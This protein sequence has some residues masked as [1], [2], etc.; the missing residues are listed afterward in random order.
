MKTYTREH[1]E[2]RIKGSGE[3]QIELVPSAGGGFQWRV[4]V[5][6]DGVM[7]TEVTSSAPAR[8][9]DLRFGASLPQVFLVKVLSGSGG[10]LR[11]VH[12]RSFEPAQIEDRHTIRI[13][14][15]E[16]PGRQRRSRP[17]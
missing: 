2:V 14:V 12:G 17:G 7:V 5:A 9:K 11:F 16:A 3:F 10:D 4:D 13:R 15:E 6:P 8:P 1:S